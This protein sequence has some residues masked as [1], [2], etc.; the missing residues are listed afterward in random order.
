MSANRLFLVCSKHPS[1][2]DAL[3]LAERSEGASRY[4][5]EWCRCRGKCGC[6]AQ[7]LGRQRDW[8]KTHAECGVDCFQLAFHRPPGWDV[9]PPAEDTPAGAVRIALLNGSETEQ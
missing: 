7:T 4:Y 1:P 3:C 8:F 5:V 9:S 6:Q 2:E